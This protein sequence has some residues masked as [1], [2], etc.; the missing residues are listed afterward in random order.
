MN[1][2]QNTYQPPSA[3]AA[4]P[5]GT[6]MGPAYGGPAA[7][8][9]PNTTAAAP[10]VPSTF[11]ASALGAQQQFSVPKG[12]PSSYGGFINSLQTGFG[13]MQQQAVQQQSELDRQLADIAGINTQ[14]GQKGAYQAQLEQQY[15]VPQF[16]QQ[17]SDLN[18]QMAQKTANYNSQYQAVEGQGYDQGLVQGVQALNRNKAAVELGGLASV[19][20]AL[21]GNIQ[22][23]MS[24]AQHTVDLKYEP[25]L[26]DL[27]NKQMFYEANK[28]NFTASQ[29]RLADRQNLIIEAQM[30]S[31]EQ[32]HADEVRLQ[33]QALKGVGSGILD[34]KVLTSPGF[35]VIQGLQPAIQAINDY[36]S[37][38]EKYGT[39]EKADAA[40]KGLLTSS[41]G[42]AL[43][44]WKTL[45]QLG[46]LS[47]ADFE[48]AENAIPKPQGIGGLLARDKR[49]ISQLDYSV[50]NANRQI[51]S[52]AEQL[53]VAYPRSSAG[54]DQ[55]TVIANGGSVRESDP[56]SLGID[57]ASSSSDSNPLGI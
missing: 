34:P 19:Q 3:N 9:A 55:L 39:Y 46:A 28:E 21:Q 54:I 4:I 32:K 33:T 50:K 51:G 24:L 48:L 57:P 10:Y 26:A 25:V 5:A 40:G 11:S 20:Q 36:K 29:K 2:T 43:S 31:I 13:G 45:A 44:A 15:G 42:N 23:A 22:N 56:L 52:I 41:Y 18:A 38:I 30:K 12:A 6:N 37:A 14:I 53:K 17:L 1:G 35:K 7:S 49:Y 47:G 27:K 8:T 16:N